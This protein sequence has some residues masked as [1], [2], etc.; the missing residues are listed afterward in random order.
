MYVGIKIVKRQKTLE[1]G[2]LFAT[3]GWTGIG[4]DVRRAR[5]A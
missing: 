4:I 1:Q 5:H 3:L 2:G